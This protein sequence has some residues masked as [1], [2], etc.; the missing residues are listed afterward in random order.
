MSIKNKYTL[1]DFINSN[2]CETKPFQNG[3]HILVQTKEQLHECIQEIKQ[4]N[5][6]GVDTEQSFMQ[7]YQAFLCLIQISTEEKDYLIDLLSIND[8]Q[9]IKSEIEQIFMDK[10]IIK[11]FY[12]GQTDIVWLQ[13]DY[14]IFLSNYFDIQIAATFLNK[15]ESW[16]LTYL[17]QKYCDYILEKKKKKLLQLSEWSNR[18]LSEEQVNYAALDSHF[19]IKIRY[20]LLHET[21][22]RL[23][24]QRTLE[25]LYK[26]QKATS[27]KYEKKPFDELFYFQAFEK[28]SKSQLSN[29][30][31]GLKSTREW[32]ILNIVFLE[33]AE[34]RERYSEQQNRYIQSVLTEESLLQITYSAFDEK[35][36]ELKIVNEIQ[37]QEEF[38]EKHSQDFLISNKDKIISIMNR[39][40]TEKDKIIEKYE[41]LCI[42]IK[43][44]MQILQ[45]RIDRK[46]KTFQEKYSMKTVPYENCQILSPNG[47]QLCNCNSKKIQW[48]LKKGLAHLISENPTI[49]KLNFQPSGKGNFDLEDQKVFENNYY[50][51][52]ERENKCVV[53]GSTEKFAKFYVIPSL[54]RR[55]FPDIL[56]SH[57]SQDILLLCMNCHQRAG[58]NSDKKIDEICQQY[59]VDKISL[60]YASVVQD[61][62]QRLSRS[63]RSF[64]KNKSQMPKEN[65]QKLKSIIRQNYQDFIELKDIQQKIEIHPAS[66]FGT[67]KQNQIKINDKLISY[68]LELDNFKKIGK[69]NSCNDFK[70]QHGKYVVDQLKNLKDLTKFV[71]MW[72][73]NFINTMQPKF[74]PKDWT[75]KPKRVEP[76]DDDQQDRKLEQIKIFSN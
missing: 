30:G 58:T 69:E 55:H 28:Q 9:Y 23:D 75:E 36:Y 26:M 42:P 6:I 22:K 56:K 63:A 16:S 66:Y 37:N 68:C 21:I 62:I 74:L 3:Q 64:Q 45:Q 2:Y 48:Y 43:N 50:Y 13:R 5:K 27:K 25:F 14:D 44:K 38:S 40:T 59:Q 52:T 46:N 61:V 20:E 67:N 60:Q 57:R 15:D 71:L 24:F 51:V 70:N 72:R 53:C 12:A 65:Q 29:L 10:N 8:K 49:I 7:T 47:Q 1:Q 35:K 32:K 76:S 41:L 54:Y 19:L 17:L 4:F 11:I 31:A 33:L 39:H 34:L 18:P 73:Q